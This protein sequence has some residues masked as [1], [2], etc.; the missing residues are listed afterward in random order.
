MLVR[1]QKHRVAPL[2]AVFLLY[3]CSCIA[4]DVIKTKHLNHSADAVFVAAE[5]VVREDLGGEIL[6]RNA[7][8]RTFRFRAWNSEFGRNES[9]S[10][11]YGHFEV[12]S[13]P[14]SANRSFA[15]LTAGYVEVPPLSSPASAV[16][17][18]GHDLRPDRLAKEFLKHLNSRLHP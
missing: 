5:K 13:D 18:H 4:S 2:G 8:A 14:A 3:A 12:R 17:V 11:G 16:A 6:E 10:S 9:K 1:F 7:S 15:T